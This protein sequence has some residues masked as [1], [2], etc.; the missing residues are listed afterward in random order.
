MKRTCGP[1]NRCFQGVVPALIATCAKDGTPNV[2]YLSQ[3][4]SVD[5]RHV[6]LSCQFFNK[7]KQNVLENPFA[8]VRIYDPFTFECYRLELKYLRAELD[9][10]LFDTMA[11]RIQAIA[12]HTGMTGV[13]KLLSADVYEVLSCEKQEGFIDVPDVVESDDPGGPRTELRGLQLV[14][15][16]VCRAP[17]L[18]TLLSTVLE[19]L[20]VAL[21]FE[22]SMF[23]MPDET[24]EKLFAV[25]SRGYGDEG[26]GAEIAIGEGLIGTVAKQRQLLRISGVENDLRYGRAIR[27]SVEQAG[28]RR[29]L[30]PEIPLAGLSDAQSHMALPL[31]VGDRLV[32]V[33]A[34]ES[35]NRLSFD[36]WDET[37]L[38]I[39]ANQVAF[40]LDNVLLRERAKEDPTPAA[41]PKP[42]EPAGAAPRAESATGPT[43]RFKF[44]RHD[45]C[46]FVDDEYLIR[47]VPGRI[48]WKLLRAHVDTGR[49]EFSNRELR[50]DPWLGLPALRDNL[51]SR[52]VLLRKRLELKCPEIK[53]PSTARGHFR[54]EPACKIELEEAG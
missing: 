36:E 41:P 51:E 20:E 21:G 18:E 50:L 44:F 1:P 2:T 37:F 38:E 33:L 4:F 27:S 10:P 31:V 24:G 52:L 29:S 23:L 53:L 39:V 16:Q 26:I 48:L 7:T 12:S 6:A 45:D 13:F 14:S 49:T 15:Q 40:G 54:V 8:C 11:L 35:K 25:A 34:V 5:E 19:S 22:H 17:D 28:G 43:R 30:K 32:G 42:A 46:V 47:N 3:V 9:G